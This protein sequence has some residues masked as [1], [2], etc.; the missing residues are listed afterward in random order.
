V[1]PFAIES[2]PYQMEPQ[3]VVD[4]SLLVRDR[5][6]TERYGRADAH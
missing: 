5:A 6:A 2:T 4:G 3:W 1:E